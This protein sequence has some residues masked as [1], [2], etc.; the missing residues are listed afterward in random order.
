MRIALLTFLLTSLPLAAQTAAPSGK[1]SPAPIPKQAAPDELTE[2][3]GRTIAKTMHWT[4]AEWLLRQTREQ[5]ENSTLMVEQLKIQPGWTVCDL[6]CGNG[7]YSLKMSRLV[8]E[9]GTILAGDIQPQMLEMLKTRAE[10]RGITNIK[11][12]QG[13]T[14][15]PK[16]PPASCDLLL[17]VD[18]Y[19][20]F[21]NPAEMLKGMHAALKPDGMVALVEFRAEDPEVPIKPEHKMSRA[22]IYKEWQASGFTV[23]REFHGLPWQHL[24]FLRKSNPGEKPVPAPPVPSAQK[25]EKPEKEEKPKSTSRGNDAKDK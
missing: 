18:V 21:G 20:E 5:E 1:P 24:L 17:L 23:A 12:I 10:G 9:K 25:E 22:Q 14:W 11:T 19:H 15:D 6:G 8:G 4:G 16:L 2:Y 13:E 3:M 7:Y